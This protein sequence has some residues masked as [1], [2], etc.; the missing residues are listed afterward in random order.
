MRIAITG[1]A[2]MVGRKLTDRLIADGTL[3]GTPIESLHLQDIVPFEPPSASFAVTTETRDLADPGVAEGLAAAG[4]VG[5]YLALWTLKNQ[6]VSDERTDGLTAA[7]IATG[8][9]L[10]ALYI[11]STID[12]NV[13]YEP[14]RV[15]NIKVEELDPKEA[16]EFRVPQPQNAK[17]IDVPTPVAPGGSPR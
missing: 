4:N 15:V 17:P 7:V 1:A 3:N 6:G 14:L 5:T 8:A 2:G 10:V 11:W 9:S 12:G 16:A 13:R